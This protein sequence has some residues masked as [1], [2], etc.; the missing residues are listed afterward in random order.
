MKGECFM[1]QDPQEQL[2][3]Y[4]KNALFKLERAYDQILK[5]QGYNADTEKLKILIELT[6][7]QV[8][9]ENFNSAASETR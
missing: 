3:S 8:P 1:S 4:L 7:E 6:R 2:E 5:T 9:Y